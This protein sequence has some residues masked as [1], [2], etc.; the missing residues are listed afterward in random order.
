M[1]PHVA[2][3]D[4]PLSPIRRKTVALIDPLWIGQH[5]MYFS[6]FSASFLRCGADVIGLCPEPLA[7]MRDLA[8]AVDDE[9]AAGLTSRVFFHELPAAKRS[10]FNGRFEG[11][12]LRTFM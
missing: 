5:L 7:A 2:A 6:Q 12:P 9:T 10:F 4:Y 1:D 3:A 11:D 8:K